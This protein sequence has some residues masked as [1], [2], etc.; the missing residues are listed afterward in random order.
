MEIV[1]FKYPRLDT[2]KARCLAR[3]LRGDSL[4]HRSFDGETHTYRLSSSI[5]DLRADGW[6]IVTTPYVADTRDPCGRR[7]R[8]GIYDL[9]AEIIKAA[10][11]EGRR[12]MWRVLEWEAIQAAAHAKNQAAA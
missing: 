1:A 3:L 5:E 10:G 12:F 2:L 11:E 8:Y 6:S 9:P 4:T 7:A